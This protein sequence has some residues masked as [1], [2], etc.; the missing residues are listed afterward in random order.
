VPGGYGALL[1]ERVQPGLR[2][3]EPLVCALHR[4]RMSYGLLCFDRQALA[5][6]SG[7]NAGRSAGGVVYLQ[8]RCGLAK[9][10][11]GGDVEPRLE[12][13]LDDRRLA[14][15][16]NAV[17]DRFDGRNRGFRT[18]ELDE[19]GARGCRSVRQAPVG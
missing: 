17:E 10:G 9:L 19:Q 6:A 2:V 5:P 14:F 8:R 4:G 16:L 3:G 18:G 12:M 11:G 7:Q 1:R 15:G 13:L